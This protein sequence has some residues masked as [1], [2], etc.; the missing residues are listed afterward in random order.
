MFCVSITC[1]HLAIDAGPE[2]AFDKIGECVPDAQ[3]AWNAVCLAD[4][5]DGGIVF[6]AQPRV[7]P[8]N[9]NWTSSGKLTHDGKNGFENY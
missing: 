3:A 1:G 8:R 9:V 6:A 4:F 2:L 5:G 7:S